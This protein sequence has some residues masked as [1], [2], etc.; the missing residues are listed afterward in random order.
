MLQDETSVKRRN[1]SLLLPGLALVVACASALLLVVAG[2]GSR[3]G[4]WHFRTGFTLLG[5]GA[6]GGVGAVLMGVLSGIPSGR[7]RQVSGIVLSLLA[8]V[9][10]LGVVA[11]PVSWRLNARQLPVIHDITTDTVQPPQFVAIL[12]LR[13]DAPNPAIYGG[14]EVAEQ[15]KRAYP[16]LRTEVLDIPSGK[17]FDRA[18]ATA[19][20]SGW[21]II[22]AD[23]EQ[24]RIEA[25][26][27]TFWFGFTDDIVIRMAAA[28]ERTLLDVR[29]VSRVG[30][31]DVGTNA[32]RI[33]SYLK[34]LRSASSP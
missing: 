23:P 27:T 26:D 10:G 24:G 3:F 6:Y 32:R 34:R 5:Y 1:A 16:D 9:C 19:K 22:S 8:V 2:I 4:W 30:K 13:K 31:S 21:R 20:A 28:G 15:Q 33:R 25:T 29:S 12:P 7:K 18:L 11:V 17:A 14:Q